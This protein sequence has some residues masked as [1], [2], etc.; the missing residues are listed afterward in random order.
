MPSSNARSPPTT[1]TQPIRWPGRVLRAADGSSI[2][3]PGSKGTD[4]RIQGVYDLGRGGFSH[5]ELTDKHGGEALDRGV[6]VPGEIRIADR[7]YSNLQFLRKLR[8]DSAGEADFIIRL[9]WQS[10][11]LR[12]PGDGDFD[13]FAYIR[14]LPVDTGAHEIAL[15]ASSKNDKGAPSLPMRLIVYRKSPE[16]TEKE[17]KRLRQVASR[18]GRQL[19]PRTLKAAEFVL[20]ATSL[21]E[22]DA[23]ADIPDAY[24]LRWQ[25]ELA[26]KRLKSLVHIDKL[27]TKT[28][29][30][31][32]GWLL[33]FMLMATLYDGMN[34]ELLESVP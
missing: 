5:L 8:R 15:Q 18:K 2:S 26:F 19:N 32:R 14:A 27:P 30:A 7:N 22:N 17:R 13:L 33:S 10:F 20:L 31:S 24:R 28:K 4:W 3:Q 25:I 6:P 12:L 9:R 1:K 29:D 21:G 34:E 16:A 23:A 11:T